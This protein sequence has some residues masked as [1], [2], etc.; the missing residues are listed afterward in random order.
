MRVSSYILL[1]IVCAPLALAAEFDTAPT[2][3]PGTIV[4]MAI[5]VA[6]IGFAALRRRNKK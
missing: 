1:L 3:E 4:M 2:P 6:G 5:G